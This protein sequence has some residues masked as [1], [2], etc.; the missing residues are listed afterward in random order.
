MKGPSPKPNL[1][2]MCWYKKISLFRNYE[3]FI[4]TY[5]KSKGTEDYLKTEVE[6]KLFKE[7]LDFWNLFENWSLENYLKIGVLGIKFKDWNF[8]N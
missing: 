4:L 2:C 7:I 3:K 6:L 1:S 5:E 8:G